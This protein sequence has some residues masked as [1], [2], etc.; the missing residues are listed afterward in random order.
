MLKGASL[1]R[2]LLQRRRTLLRDAAADEQTFSDIALIIIQ[3]MITLI[4]IL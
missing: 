2:A 1:P 3:M 4:M